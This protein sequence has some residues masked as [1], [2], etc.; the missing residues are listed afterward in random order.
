MEP[1][2][3]GKHP[4]GGATVKDAI[5]VPFNWQKVA[6]PAGK[7]ALLHVKIALSSA[8]VVSMLP[9]VELPLNGTKE[10]PE[11]AEISKP[12]AKSRP[13]LS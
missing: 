11:F 9:G 10:S 7:A 5:T 13:P 2:T 1:T 6:V 12:S 4:A 8:K 3:T